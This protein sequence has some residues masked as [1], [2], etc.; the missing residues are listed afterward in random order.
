MARRRTVRRS[1]AI[2]GAPGR[3]A[4]AH[5][6]MRDPAATTPRRPLESQ[7]QGYGASARTAARRTTRTRDFAKPADRDAEAA[8]DVRGM[9]NG[10]RP[11]CAASASSAGTHCSRQC[12]RM[13]RRLLFVAVI[14]LLSAPAVRRAQMPD[15]SQMNGLSMPTPDLPNGTVS[16]RVIRGQ[17]TNNLQGVA[18]DLIGAGEPRHGQTG[19]DGRALFSGVPAGSTVHAVAAVNGERRE[20]QPFEVPAQGGV[21]TILVFSETTSAPWSGAP[22]TGPPPAPGVTAGTATLSIGGRLTRRRRVQRRHAAGLLS[23]RNRQP[24]PDRGLTIERTRLRHATGAE[25]T[26]VLEGSTRR[27]TQGTESHRD[28]PVSAGRHAAPDRVSPGVLRQ[29]SDAQHHV[30]A[31]MDLVAVAVQRLG[32]MSLKSPQLTRTS[33]TA[34]SGQPFI[35]GTGPGIPAGTALSLQLLGPSG[36]RS[37]RCNTSHWG[38]RSASCCSGSGSRWRPR[39]HRRDIARATR[40]RPDATRGWRRWLRWSG[41]GRTGVGV[42]RPVRA[43]ACR[44]HGATRAHLRRARRTEAG[45]AEAGTSTRERLRLRHAHRDRRVAHVRAA[46][47]AVATSRCRAPPERSLRLARSRTEQG[48]RRCSSIL[49]TLLAPSSGDVRYGASPRPRRQARTF[50]RASACSATISISIPS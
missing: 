40:S 30:S 14:A 47:R 36:A 16:V 38:W 45:R 43:A 27:P 32:P 34:L 6:L 50:A 31:A 12:E 22:T 41:T 39:T 46:A 44:A 18:V 5:R 17:L 26:T 48:S 33:E 37:D 19:A 28:G 1:N 10:R 8:A 42:R 9:R 15:P 35:M 29:G 24:R 3:D 11:R 23:P 21:R 13:T 7:P 4:R 2:S 20:S 49:A 25:G